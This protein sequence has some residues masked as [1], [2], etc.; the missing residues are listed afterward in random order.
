MASRSAVVKKIMRLK[1]KL[2][3]TTES[4]TVDASGF[5]PPGVGVLVNICTG[6]LMIGVSLRT[7]IVRKHDSLRGFVLC[8]THVLPQLGL[9]TGL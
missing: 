8:H 1:L 7:W 4:A 9:L 5:L 2:T 3:A 6:N